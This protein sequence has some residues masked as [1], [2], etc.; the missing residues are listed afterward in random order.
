MKIQIIDTF[1]QI[2]EY[3]EDNI[4]FSLETYKTYA[5]GIS[6]SLYKKCFDDASRYD[7]EKDL[8]P[9][10]NDALYRHFDRIES[11]HSSIAEIQSFLP[12]KASKLFDVDLDITIL[13]YLGLCNG[14]GWAT[15]MDGNPAI[16]LGVEKIAELGWHDKDGMCDLICHE[17]AHL[18]HF[19]LRKDM[20]K[21]CQPIWQLYTE[22]FASR[23][24]QLLYKEDFYHQNQEGWLSFCS[25][26]IRK[27][28]QTYGKC[29]AKGE[30]TNCFFGD[31]NTFMGQSNIGYYLG[32][33]FVRELEKRYTVQNIAILTTDAI[34]KE[35]A[36]FLN[37]E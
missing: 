14:A 28:K 5:N 7:Y 12:E 6:P 29:L 27:I 26:N 35:L 21:P 19:A 11:A 20:P 16:L 9:V 3:K 34:E 25:E 2:V 32:C 17:T 30:S 23:V 33:E 15:A 37:E 10:L 13:F 36:L 24:S 22:G 8:M 18:L 4:E 1:P 31:W